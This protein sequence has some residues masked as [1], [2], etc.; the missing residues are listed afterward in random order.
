MYWL[1]YKAK[2]KRK[3]KDQMNAKNYFTSVHSSTH[4][5]SSLSVAR[6]RAGK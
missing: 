5:V 2:V 1:R 3:R 6:T 4:K